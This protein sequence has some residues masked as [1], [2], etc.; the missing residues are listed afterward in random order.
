MPTVWTVADPI[1]PESLDQ[2]TYYQD[3]QGL[4]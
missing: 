4:F 3:P 1:E 2:E